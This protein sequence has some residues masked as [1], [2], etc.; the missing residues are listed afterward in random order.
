M[1][2]NKSFLKLGSKY[3]VEVIYEVMAGLFRNVLVITNEP[4]RY[5]E[6]GY[7]TFADI[8]KDKG[9]LGGIHS[10]LIHSGTEKNF[11]LSCDMPLIN[12]SVLRFIIDYPLES[13]IKVAFADNFI[14]QLCGLY[15]KS[16]IPGIE[17]ELLKESDSN[18]CSVLNILESSG[19]AVINI[20]K[21]MNNYPADSFMNMN[22]RENY[23]YAKKLF[24]LRY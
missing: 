3:V 20:E 7:I 19:S 17:S 4:E 14:Q 16:L 6:L 12:E 1:G 9:P 18:K 11:I 5:S 22:N 23:L 2:M 15:S 13:D 24:A 21:E 10:G 8:Y